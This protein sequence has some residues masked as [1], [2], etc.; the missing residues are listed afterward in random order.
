MKIISKITILL[1]AVF[2]LSNCAK[3][4]VIEVNP[5]F[6][7]SIART[8]ETKAYVGTPIY[9]IPSGSGEYLTLYDGTVGHVYG[10]VGATGTFFDKNDSLPITYKKQ[11]KY[12]ITVVAASSVNFGKSF[13]REVKSYTLE[14][15]D[16]RNEITYFYIADATGNV[17][18]SGDIINDSIIFRVPD[19]VTDLNFKPT[20]VLSSD[21]SKVYVNGA[22]Q[23]SG[24]SQNDFSQV[25]TYKVVSSANTEKTYYVKA[26]KYAASNEKNLL[27][28]SLAK[29][30]AE[31]AY[32]NSNGEIAVIDNAN[33]V[34]NLSVN[35]GTMKTSS[36]IVLESPY[37][38]TVYING[39]IYS[40][41]KKY[42]LSTITEIKVV[43]QNNSV[44]TYTLNISDQD[45]VSNF[46]FEGLVPAPV[47][48]IDKTTKTITVDVLNGTDINHL[49]AKWNGSVGKVTVSGVEQVN[50]AT[51][52]NFSA[53]V[54][55]TFY[56]GTTAGDSY[57]VVVNVK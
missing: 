4:D 6:S 34:I 27:K 14:V 30:D 46:T 35:Y 47:G 10:E 22:E 26:K 5:D 40:N 33:S 20:F 56:K 39:I 2:G 38:S 3:E 54:T 43:A 53:P 13:N 23:T 42:N 16:A 48:R 17:M 21:L 19:V 55:Y 57:T 12:T 8:G 28:F 50:G 7:L 31:A 45:P 37:A 25:V 52:N 44:K 18:Y 9:V 51:V 1:I 49:I 41:T 15:V 24:V 36:K 32:R 11:G 29:Y